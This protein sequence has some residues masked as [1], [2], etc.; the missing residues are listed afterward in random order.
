MSYKSFRIVNTSGP[1]LYPVILIFLLFTSCNGITEKRQYT[2][3]AHT[4][5]TY[6]DYDA[7]GN[8]V[9]VEEKEYNNN[10]NI[11]IQPPKSVGTFVENNPFSLTLTTEPTTGEEGELWIA[12]AVV[13]VDPYLGEIL[14]QYWELQ[15]AGD[16][17]TGTLTDTHIAES[18]AMNELWAWEEISPTLKM[19]L[20]FPIDKGSILRGTI[21]NNEIRLHI[22]GN[23]TDQTRPF[24]SEIVATRAE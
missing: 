24:V 2:G 9:F 19:V 20:P 15:L 1:A 8:K 14:L 5:I 4:T 21:N 13:L 10:L 3:T 11:F 7:Q 6:L 18:A 12:S 22:E 16:T 23:T 17:V